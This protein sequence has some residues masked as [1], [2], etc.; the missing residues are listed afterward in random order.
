MISAMLKVC[1][2]L[3]GF[4]QEIYL[5][6]PGVGTR[7]ER[8]LEKIGESCLWGEA[9]NWGIDLRQ[10]EKYKQRNEDTAVPGN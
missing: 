1:I 10:R 6:N 5:S 2:V 4:P 3:R 8:H 9:A 7:K